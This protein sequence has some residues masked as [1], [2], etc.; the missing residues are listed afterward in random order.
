M[1]LLDFGSV[2]Y[3]HADQHTGPPF[4]MKSGQWE[5]SATDLAS[6]NAALAL[7]SETKS[8]CFLEKPWKLRRLWQRGCCTEWLQPITREAQF[9]HCG[10]IFSRVLFAVPDDWFLSKVP[11]PKRTPDYGKPIAMR[12]K[13]PIVNSSF[14]DSVNHKIECKAGVQSV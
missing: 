5:A 8:W 2:R 6:V 9:Q 12:L 11:G 10:G 13:L 14:L 4:Q 7:K 3:Q 1:S